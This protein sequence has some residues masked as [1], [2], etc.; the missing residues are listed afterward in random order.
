MDQ[1]LLRLVIA[2]L[3]EATA[4][5]SLWLIGTRL[6][7]SLAV[8]TASFVF[9]RIHRGANAVQDPRRHRQL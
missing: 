4:Q 1:V 7:L 5:D 2:A 6:L 3:L 8:G 9:A